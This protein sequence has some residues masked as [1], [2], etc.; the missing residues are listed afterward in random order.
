MIYVGYRSN[1]AFGC[2][3]AQFGKQDNDTNNTLD[4]LRGLQPDDIVIIHEGGGIT[5]PQ[6]PAQGDDKQKA[7][8]PEAVATYFTDPDKL[9]GKVR[10]YLDRVFE[11]DNAPDKE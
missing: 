9:P 11:R 10:K 5:G 3:K 1:P 4:I 2:S 8:F 6:D 7:S